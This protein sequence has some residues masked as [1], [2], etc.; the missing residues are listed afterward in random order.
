MNLDTESNICVLVRY[1]SVYRF[2]VLWMVT[3]MSVKV[4]SL[5]QSIGA[6]CCPLLFHLQRGSR[7]EEEQ[8]LLLFRC[9]EGAGPRGE[10]FLVLILTAEVRMPELQLLEAEAPA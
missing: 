5:T 9:D 4:K 6:H 8:Y 10:A 2:S 1:V 7:M 3:L